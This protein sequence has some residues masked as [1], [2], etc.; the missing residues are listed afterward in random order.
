M[1]HQDDN[2]QRGQL[3]KQLFDQC[4]DLAPNE[5][6]KVIQQA[7][8]TDDIK[9]HVKKLL[10]HTTEEVELTQAV[11]DSVQ[12]SM[13]IKPLMPGVKIGAYE[14]MRQLAEGGQGEVWLANRSDGEFKHQV[15]IKFLK[16]LHNEVELARFQAER[17]LMANLRH[18]NIAQLLDGGAW[19]DHRP[20]MVL[21][22]VE[23]FPVT[24]YCQQQHFSLRQYLTCFLQICEAISYAH[25]HSVIH[26]DIKPSNVLIAHG[27]TVKLL[28]FGIAKFINQDDV[29]T[30]TQ[31]VM[32]L[33]YSSPEQ[34]TGK[35]VST[36]TD[37]YALGLLLYEMLTG[38]R[39]QAVESDVPSDVIHDI[40]QG[41]PQLPSRLLHD[42]PVQR[43][44][45]AKKL[46][47]DLDHLI[48]MAIRKEPH[49]RYPTVAAM[50]KDI[51]NFLD[52]KPLL[53]AG[54]SL[55]YHINKFINR[56]P[57]VTGLAAVVIAFMV[58]LP[59]EMMNNQ[60]QL[61]L[62]RDKALLAQQQA[63][64]QSIIA[65]RTTD[66][67][68]NI[69]ES[70][71]PL[72]DQGEA[73]NLNDVLASAE[74]QLAFGLDDQ[75]AIKATLLSKLASI[76]HQLGNS[77]LA[78]NHY[79]T[80]LQIY[81]QSGDEPGQAFAL[82]QLAV[83]SHFANDQTAALDYRSQAAAFTNKLTDPVDAAWNQARIA[84]LDNYLRKDDQV[85]AALTKTL[86]ELQVLGIEE[87]ELLGRIYNEL[88]I[89][90]GS[91][92]QGL[93]YIEKSGTLR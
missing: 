12:A 93:A 78:A 61:R 13:D 55:W 43:T 86:A 57:L 15:A 53:A 7:A 2:K 50:A 45:P 62:E 38:Q 18:P 30:L 1:T 47:G 58:A 63:E 83:M 21:E 60:K 51:E 65:N 40:T 85:I 28:D 76:Q 89:A 31:P 23:G 14:L 11:V 5:Q 81:Q 67:L 27:G 77:Q 79:K 17:A 41:S 34:V 3:I 22:L 66:F 46:Q 75:P 59:M 71:S 8:V 84:T 44:F 32:T 73:I 92:E 24:D 52:G 88:S 26:R 42:N 48:L 90:S 72:A 9:I 4:V 74:R 87:P 54:D 91:N 35:P 29:D 69:L 68:V 10:R 82:G 37:V 33:A 6:I 20:Y 16:P 39:A 25:S 49:R 64:T 19:L 56:K 36:A 70:A 80:V